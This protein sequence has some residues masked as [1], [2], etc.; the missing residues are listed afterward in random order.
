MF[1]WSSVIEG[2]LPLNHRALG[3]N[4]GAARNRKDERVGNRKQSLGDQKGPSI[5]VDNDIIGI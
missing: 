5:K 2:L 1:G 4:P 3:F